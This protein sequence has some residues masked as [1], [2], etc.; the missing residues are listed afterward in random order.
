[1]PVITKNKHRKLIRE[2]SN[3]ISCLNDFLECRELKT[4]KEGLTRGHWV[5]PESMCATQGSSL[6]IRLAVEDFKAILAEIKKLK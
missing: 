5:A 2:L 1:M 3:R 4:A 6:E